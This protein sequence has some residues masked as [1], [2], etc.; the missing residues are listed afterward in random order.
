MT[1][2]PASRL[3]A[4][5]TMSPRSVTFYSSNWNTAQTITVSGAQDDDAQSDSAKITHDV[6][7]ALSDKTVQ[8]YVEDDEIREALTLPPGWL[9]VVEGGQATY[10][11]ALDW[12]PE[13]TITV[14][15]LTYDRDAGEISFSPASLSFDSSNYGT[16]QVMTVTGLQDSDSD[17][18]HATVLHDLKTTAGSWTLSHLRPRALFVGVL[19]DDDPKTPGRPSLSSTV[20][21]ANDSLTVNWSAPSGGGPV[22]GYEVRYRERNGD[23]GWSSHSHTGTS[24]SATI[25]G[26]ARGTTYEVQVRAMNNTRPGRWSNT[27][28]GTTTGERIELVLSAPSLS[29]TETSYNIYTVALSADPG[30]TATTTIT[31]GDTGAATVSPVSLTFNSG[32]W[33]AP[34]TV[35]VIGTDDADQAHEWVSVTHS[36]TAGVAGATLSVWVADDDP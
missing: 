11:I 24:T 30:G 33:S 21:P 26:L 14:T 6:N 32:N 19:D 1:V 27:R 22:T 12:V 28:S 36:A 8:V 9:T 23:G 5:V 10:T 25:G 31:S 2:G 29:V 15:P 13:G 4:D 16:P 18:E 20:T 3:N 34:Q 17:D 35:A 7:G